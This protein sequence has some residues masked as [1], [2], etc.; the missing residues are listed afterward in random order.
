MSRAKIVKKGIELLIEAVT[1]KKGKGGR[2]K[3]KRGPKP[4][5][6]AVAKKSVARKK[7]EEPL[8]KK[9]KA[10][11]QRLSGV[12]LKDLKNKSPSEQREY[13]KAKSDIADIKEPNLPR[14]RATGPPGAVPV[15]QGPLLSKVLLPEN[16]SK[17]RIRSLIKQGKAKWVIDKNGKRKLVSTGEFA[18]ER[19]TVGEEMGLSGKGRLP[20]EADIEK[21][22][23]FEIKKH[24]GKVKGY[25]KGG[26]I[27]RGEEEASKAQ[28]KA[29]KQ[30][31]KYGREKDPVATAETTKRHARNKAKLEAIAEK[32]KQ[33]FLADA[34]KFNKT[35]YIQGRP[36]ATI[37]NI[38]ARDVDKERTARGVGAAKRGF[39]RATYSDKWY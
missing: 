15:E 2:P 34:E 5:P 6:K 19:G 12:K 29:W 14:R 7:P 16:M 35:S 27:N 31:I 13:L 3:R 33:D 38:K 32:K 21:M 4:K 18:P 39:G 8:S 24:G 9:A 25:K 37:R 10:E 17:A 22:G 30:V 23:G 28:R 11:I 1:P 36:R 26:S 20:T